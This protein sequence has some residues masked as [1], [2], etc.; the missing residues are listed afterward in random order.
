MSRAPKTP[1]D[2]D[3]SSAQ[4]DVVDEIRHVKDLVFLRNL[5]SMRAATDAELREY[6][7]AIDD[8]RRRLAETAKRALHG[9]ATA[10]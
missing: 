6:D 8:A 5:L 10:V 2:R 1:P 9:Y 7:A 4:A 3:T